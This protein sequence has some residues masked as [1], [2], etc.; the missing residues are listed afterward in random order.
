MQNCCHSLCLL[1]RHQTASHRRQIAVNPGRKLPPRRSS[2]IHASLDT[3]LRSL[4]I[5]MQRAVLF[6]NWLCKNNKKKSWATN[7]S[8]LSSIKTSRQTK[9]KISKQLHKKM[10]LFVVKSM[11]DPLQQRNSCQK[12]LEAVTLSETQWKHEI[13]FFAQSFSDP[14]NTRSAFQGT[15]KLC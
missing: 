9:K 15:R 11:S 12:L 6:P 8:E 3:L 13:D 5:K 14:S 2:F 4:H 10:F 7:W 1:H